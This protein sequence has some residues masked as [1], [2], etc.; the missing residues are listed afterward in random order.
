MWT[1]AD[2][3]L[4]KDPQKC[5]KLEEYDRILER[6]F[7]VKLEPVGTLKRREQ[8]LDFFSL[9]IEG[10]KKS[11][12]EEL[13]TT[14]LSKCSNKAKRFFKSAADC[15]IASKDIITAAATPCLPASV[16]CAGVAVLL[17]FCVQAADQRHLLFDG[18]DTISGSICRIAEYEKLLRNGG[19]QQT[20]EVTD[21][22]TTACCNIIEFQARAACFLQGNPME[23]AIRNAFK[24]D[25][26]DN[27]LSAINEAETKVKD[28]AERK[29]M[30][31]ICKIFVKFDELKDEIGDKFSKLAETQEA[32]DRKQRVDTFLQLLYNNTCSYKASKDRNRERVTGTCDWFTD[33]HLFKEWNLPKE[34]CRETSGLLY[35]TADPGCGKSVLSRYLIDRVLPDDGRTVCYFFFKDDFEDQKSSISALCTL[36]HQLFDLNPRLLTDAILDKQSHCGEKFVEFSTLWEMF[37]NVT[38]C[39]ETVCVLDALDECRESDRSQLIGAIKGS[40]VPGLKL[41]LTSRPYEHIR[42]EVS[43]KLKAPMASIHLQGDCGRTADKIAQEIKLVVNSRINET[44][45]FFRLEP[46]ESQLI[47]EQLESVPNRTYLWVT[48][49]FDGLMDKKSG[50]TKGDIM[51]MTKTLP[52][53]VYDAYEKILNKSQDREKAKRLLHLILGAKRPLSLSEMSVALAFKGQQSCDDVAKN[54][55]PESRIQGTI[56]DLCGLFVI[57]VDERIYL[58]HQTAREFLAHDDSDNKKARKKHLSKP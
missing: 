51:D 26:W 58:L 48:L 40:Q 24:W 50:I 17:S 7:D 41:L 12:T 4:R 29:S 6:H 28:C 15:I 52:Q 42:S 19:N 22:I 34:S 30:N 11:E 10:L 46:D 36:L 31:D 5:K 38:S 21:L 56:R 57:V 8:F 49:I 44:A 43:L 47:R 1:I 2:E 27:L 54:I 35:V 3:K 23:S 16:A 9:E 25:G 37:V 33:H 32:I 39:Q 18:L 14:R 13:N 20:G 55:I 45:E 53:G